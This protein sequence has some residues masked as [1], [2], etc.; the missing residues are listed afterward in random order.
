[1]LNPQFEQRTSRLGA[2]CS[3]VFGW[4]VGDV[5]F[6]GEVAIGREPPSIAAIDGAD[7]LQ[8]SWTKVSSFVNAEWVMRRNPRSQLCRPLLW[9]DGAVRGGEDHRQRRGSS[10]WCGSGGGGKRGPMSGIIL[11][12]H[13]TPA[14]IAS[15]SFN[16]GCRR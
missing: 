7:R 1:M 11:H 16:T 2:G 4:R 5:G 3:N 9:A 14:R 6:R 10:V 12:V 8:G 15:D 13:T